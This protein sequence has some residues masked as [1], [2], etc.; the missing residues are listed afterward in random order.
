MWICV[1]CGSS[2]G[3]GE[4]YLAAARELGRLLAERNIGLVYGGARVGTMGALADAAT[5]AGG[6]VVGV[7]PQPLV[8]R[9][10]AHPG[11]NELHAV[12]DM[13]ER[14]ALMARQA[15]A[16][17]ALPGG[18]G[19][20]E[21]VF[22]VWTWAHLGLHEKPLALLDVDGFYTHLHRFVQHMVDESFLAEASRDLVT[23]DPAPEVVVT[24]LARKAPLDVLAWAHTRQGR[25][26]AARTRGS[27][28]FYL[29]GGKRETGESDTAAL[30]REVKEETSVLLHPESVAPLTVVHAPA[31]GYPSGTQVRLAAFQAQGDG[32][33]EAQAEVAELAWLSYA[34][35]ERCAPGVQLVMDELQQRGL[36]A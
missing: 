28:L 27:E 7:I 14:K 35:R 25:M 32:E 3:S 16:F 2:T 15:D 4:R 9:E 5:E 29:P 30:A 12:T 11:L 22:E 17:V 18:V 13:H 23:I 36:V 33:P 6:T 21:E 20:L 10:L 31:H 24:E 19:T 34:E 26:L 8:E 1:F